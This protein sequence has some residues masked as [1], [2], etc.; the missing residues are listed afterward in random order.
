MPV[1]LLAT[2]EGKGKGFSLKPCA[3]VPAHVVGVS[4]SH[5]GPWMLSA[6]LVLATL[7]FGGLGFVHYEA[8]MQTTCDGFGG[9]CP[10]PPPHLRCQFFS[11]GF[12]RRECVV[13]VSPLCCA[14][15]CVL[16]GGNVL[17]ELC[18]PAPSLRFG[19]NFYGVLVAWLLAAVGSV[20]L[21]AADADTAPAAGA[22]GVRF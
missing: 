19:A 6:A 5:V 14:A 13:K 22:Q 16:C 12:E 11:Y 21:D 18:C 3:V 4:P 7:V 17:R 8:A 20:L 10:H 1:M 2:C 9:R 15:P